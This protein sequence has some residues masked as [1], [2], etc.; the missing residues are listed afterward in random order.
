MNVG[1]TGAGTK[2][3]GPESG[4]IKEVT[5]FGEQESEQKS[6]RKGL[7]ASTVWSLWVQNDCS[8]LESF[9]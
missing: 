6:E 7:R 5:A 9:C 4:E 3:Q 2:E 1:K 8:I